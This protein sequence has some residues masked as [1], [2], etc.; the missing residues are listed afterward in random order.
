MTTDNLIDS[1]PIMATAPRPVSELCMANVTFLS[2][3]SLTLSR[4]LVIENFELTFVPI[5]WH[6]WTIIGEGGY[7]VGT[8]WPRSRFY[9]AISDRYCR[10]L[11][12]PCCHLVALSIGNLTRSWPTNAMDVIHALQ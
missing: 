11:Y 10:S 8:A 12:Y 6:L 3:L 4:W 9:R 5:Y 1:V 7:T 2:V